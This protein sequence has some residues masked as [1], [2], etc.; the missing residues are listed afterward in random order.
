MRPSSTVS[1][2]MRHFFLLLV[3]G[4]L[5]GGC[6]SAD[7]RS[8]KE[9]MARQVVF[10]I[11]ESSDEMKSSYAKGTLESIG[12]ESGGIKIQIIIQEILNLH[13]LKKIAQW[14]IKSLGLHAI[15]AEIGQKRKIDELI[16]EL[17]TDDRVETVQ[18]VKS[19]KLHTYNDPYFH[20]QNTVNSDDIE[21]IHS[22]AT[23]KD[24]VVGV[25][26]TGIDRGHSELHGRVI[27]SR[28]F[29]DHDQHRFDQDEHGTT[30]A[31]VIGSAANNDLG[32][33]GVAPDVQLM[34][35]KACW[36]DKLTQQ[37]SCDSISLMR[38]LA[39][40]LNQEPDILNLSLSGPYDPLIEMLLRMANDQGVV[41]VGAKDDKKGESFPASMPEVI[42]VGTPLGTTG[43]ASRVVLA[44]GTDILTTTP[45][46]TYAFRSGSSL[47]SAYVSGI[48]ALM[49][50][51][52]PALS[53][54]QIEMQLRNT[55]TVKID[56]V[57]VVDMCAA[58]RQENEICPNTSLAQVDGVQE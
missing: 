33:V 38:A 49:K 9:K 14:P 4:V 47:A 18:A 22:L 25:I 39:T 34:A 55:A 21:H 13:N 52:Q 56:S 8:L 23:G 11:N 6:A 48:A 30:V 32:I 36:H 10:T 28:N 57:P 41:L 42:A 12:D 58:L 1:P 51:R 37:A 45:G 46:S 50:E 24:V 15:V 2:S 44:P 5:L 53:G 54:R 29:V 3:L 26:D 7:I 19:Y 40:V 27:Y 31:G 17:E 35:F 16:S 20:L 43:R